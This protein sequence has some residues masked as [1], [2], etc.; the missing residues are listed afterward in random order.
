MLRGTARP[1]AFSDEKMNLYRSAWDNDGAMSAM[2]NWYRAVFRS[3][4]SQEGEQRVSVPTL[5]VVAPDDA[6]IPSDLTR[7]STKYLDNGR[8][9]EL[10]T[11]THWILQEEPE[12][13]SRILID[14][15]SQ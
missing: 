7:A 6:F 1:G 8:L 9:L 10:E 13:T 3:P 15:F 14:F 11:G 5:L 2:I 12:R 4:P